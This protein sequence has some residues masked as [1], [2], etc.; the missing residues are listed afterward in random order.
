MSP[1]SI[2]K[3][4]ISLSIIIFLVFFLGNNVLSAYNI[5]HQLYT[6]SIV[7]LCLINLIP[8]FHKKI[9]KNGSLRNLLFFLT[10][11]WA[12]KVFNGGEGSI[13]IG[14]IVFLPPYIYL[15]YINS[16]QQPFFYKKILY[17]AYIIECSIAIIERLFISHVFKYE[18]IGI[19]VPIGD[20]RSIGLYGHPLQNALIV[21]IF[22]NFI[23]I[24]E[25][26][27][28]KKYIMAFFGLIAIFCFN[29]RAAI[30]ISISSVF[31]YFFHWLIIN[32]ASSD[33]ISLWNAFHS[34]HSIN[35]FFI[36]KRVI[37]WA[38]I[39]YGFI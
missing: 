19:Q 20:F 13:M 25:N 35:L 28:K 21:L 36:S 16:R 37:G 15:C 7:L 33:K 4:N 1:F 30:V 32:K 11:Y 39:F 17:L 34:I 10:I 14:I 9:H 12:W 38:F 26:D 24:Y 29:A 6:L 27:N 5:P 2:P 31:I 23:L 8:S 22:V 3:V 18:K